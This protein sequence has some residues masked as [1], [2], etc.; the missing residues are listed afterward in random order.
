VEK[1]VGEGTCADIKIVL[2]YVKIR[3]NTTERG[4]DMANSAHGF[5]KAV[6]GGFNR[7]DVLDYFERFARENQ[8]QMERL[9]AELKRTQEEQNEC[10]AQMRTTLEEKDSAIE[11]ARAELEAARARIAELEGVVTELREKVARM[12]PQARGYEILKDRVATVELDAHQKAQATLDRAKVQADGIRA[13]TVRWMGEFDAQY[14]RLRGQVRDCADLAIRAEEAFTAL[15][16]DY[17]GLRKKGMEKTE[18]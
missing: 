14:A 18:S 10:G 12:E 6:F 11:S 1:E 3:R 5:R 2:Q 13:D 4:V 16:E 8:E 7:R 15:E 9:Q 17:Q